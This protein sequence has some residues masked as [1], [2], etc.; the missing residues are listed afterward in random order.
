MPLPEE[1][2]YAHFIA[3]LYHITHMP[4]TAELPNIIFV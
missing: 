3:G 1:D 2:N 4:H